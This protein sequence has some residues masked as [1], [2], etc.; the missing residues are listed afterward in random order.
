MNPIAPYNPR[1]LACHPYDPQ[2]P[3]VASALNDLIRN[4]LPDV[5]VEHIGSTSVPG[6]AGKGF[7]DL[8]VLYRDGSLEEAKAG[9]AT[10]GF[11]KQTS[12]DPF[13]EDRPMRVGSFTFK[14]SEYQIHTHVIDVNSTEAIELRAFRER[15]RQDAQ[16]RDAY[17]AE[18]RRI[19]EA[20]ISDHVE[21]CIEKSVFVEKIL[22]L[23]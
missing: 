14:G 1:P 2:A 9:L 21:Y 6:C 20:G 12:R 15:L 17:I 4:L 3:E 13:P 7:I 11:Q 16:L 23:N 10:L 8:M 22:A 19:L 18:K 5:E